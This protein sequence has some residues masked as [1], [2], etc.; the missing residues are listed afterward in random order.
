MADDRLVN[1]QF[2]TRKFRDN[3]LDP[4]RFVDEEIPSVTVKLPYRSLAGRKRA[5]LGTHTGTYYITGTHYDSYPGSY[6]LRITRLSVYSGSRDVIWRLHHSRVGTV[7][8]IYFPA[9]GQEIQIGGPRNPIMA[10][11][12]GTIS[13]GFLNAGSAHWLGYHLEGVVS[14]E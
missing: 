5:P 11:G 7:E 12:P 3:I 9:A 10:L 6:G 8:E 1:R 2:V 13:F 4:P 14:H